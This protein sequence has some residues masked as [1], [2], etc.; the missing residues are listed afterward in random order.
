V[1][2]RTRNAVDVCAAVNV[3]FTRMR[4]IENK[5]M[6]QLIQQ[7]KSNKK[8]KSKHVAG[9]C[10]SKIYVFYDKIKVIF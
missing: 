1:S 4:T 10:R 8:Q 7:T 3:D 9:A 5:N 2:V 6:I